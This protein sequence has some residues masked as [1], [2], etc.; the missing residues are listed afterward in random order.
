MILLRGAYVSICVFRII[1][2]KIKSE[3]DSEKAAGYLMSDLF[4]CLIIG[5]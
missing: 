1:W 5:V 4:F 2:F 3:W